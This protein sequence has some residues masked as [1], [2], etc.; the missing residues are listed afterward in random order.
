LRTEAGAG[1]RRS[2]KSGKNFRAQLLC[3]RVIA[4][5]TTET[6]AQKRDI[7]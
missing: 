2:E 4:C 6:N 1:G 5:C 7:E 3:W